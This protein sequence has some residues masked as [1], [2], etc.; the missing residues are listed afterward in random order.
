M[1]LLYGSII[2]LLI[3]AQVRIVAAFYIAAA[4]CQ[5]GVD[6]PTQFL[7]GPMNYNYAPVT[8]IYNM[9]NSCLFDI[10]ILDRYMQHS[11]HSRPFGCLV[12]IVGLVLC[13]F[14][15][16]EGGGSE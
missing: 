13:C 12:V 6:G 14:L 1:A 5:L 8:C 3:A 4:Y 2:P 15:D 9:C 11:M 10:A 7:W 16:R